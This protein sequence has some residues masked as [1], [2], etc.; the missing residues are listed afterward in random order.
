MKKIEC[1]YLMASSLYLSAAFLGLLNPTTSRAAQNLKNTQIT[2]A[3]AAEIERIRYKAELRREANWSGLTRK[4]IFRVRAVLAARKARADR[5]AALY[6]QFKFQQKLALAEASAPKTYVYLNG[7]PPANGDFSSLS[8]QIER[9]PGVT[10]SKPRTQTYAPAQTSK[11]IYPDRFYRRA[12]TEDGLDRQD[13]RLD[14]QQSRED[15]E[16]LLNMAPFGVPTP[17]RPGYMTS[18]PQNFRG[19]IDVR[20]YS[21]G[22][23]VIDPYTGQRVRVP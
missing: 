3:Q 12:G 4:E 11:T 2:A 13:I 9:A 6:E 20:D 16:A 14:I 23:T 18:P 10:Y 22:T 15:A 5:E 17:G 7:Q 8:Q 19:F 1:G 21:P